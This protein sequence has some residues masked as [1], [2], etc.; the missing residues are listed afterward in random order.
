MRRREF[1]G[2]QGRARSKN[3]AI[4]WGGRARGVVAIE[5]GGTS[6]FK[7]VAIE[8]GADQSYKAL[9]GLIRP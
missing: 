3:V 9:K 7:I 1:Q 4:E 5:R 8:W 2:A 6:K